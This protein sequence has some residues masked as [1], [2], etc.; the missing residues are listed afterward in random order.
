MGPSLG[1]YSRSSMFPAFG[2]AAVKGGRISGGGVSEFL[3]CICGNGLLV[4]RE[5]KVIKHLKQSGETNKLDRLFYF[6]FKSRI[7]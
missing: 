3:F 6:Y 7:L 2:I 5:W 4:I 1:K